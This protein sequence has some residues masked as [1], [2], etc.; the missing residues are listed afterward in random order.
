MDTKLPKRFRQCFG[1]LGE[2]VLRDHRISI[3]STILPGS[4]IPE[5]KVSQIRTLSFLLG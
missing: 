5:W 1:L 2:R 3:A 4:V